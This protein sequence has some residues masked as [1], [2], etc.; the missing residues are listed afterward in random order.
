MS[1]TV[2]G[3]GVN[4]AV[5]P[6]S[7]YTGD[8]VMDC[9]NGPIKLCGGSGYVLHGRIDNSAGCTVTITGTWK[10][11]YPVGLETPQEE[12]FAETLNGADIEGATFEYEP[13]TEI[14][15]GNGS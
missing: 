12:W 5:L 3:N 10:I 6:P 8:L 11:Y 9:S 15:P 13:A 4:C 14:G 1:Y 7:P 2:V